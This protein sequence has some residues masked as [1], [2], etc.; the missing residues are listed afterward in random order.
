[1]YAPCLFKMINPAVKGD[2]SSGCM[3]LLCEMLIHVIYDFDTI[4]RCLDL[5]ET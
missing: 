3:I 5:I 4:C 2:D 1:M